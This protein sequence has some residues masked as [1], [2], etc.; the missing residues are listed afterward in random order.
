MELTGSY[1]VRGLSVYA[2]LA[3]QR[4]IGKDIVSS[5]FNFDAE[6]LGLHCRSLHPSGSRAADH[7]LRRRLLCVERH[8]LQCRYAAR[9]RAAL[10]PGAAG[11]QRHPN[12]DHLPYYTQV[13]LGAEHDFDRQ[14]VSGLTARIDFINLLDKVYEIRNGTGVGVGAPQYGPRRGVFFGVTQTF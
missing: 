10:R 4:A 13:N 12:G 14:G 5:Q 8:P 2:N 7:R 11:R 9:I 6:E 1:R 3:T